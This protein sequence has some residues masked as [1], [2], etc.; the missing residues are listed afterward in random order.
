MTAGPVA[1]VL[2]CE[3]GDASCSNSFR[4]VLPIT[5]AMVNVNEPCPLD[6]GDTTWMLLSTLLVLTMMPALAIFEAGLLRAKNTM[7]II[8]QIV[9]GVV[10]L[11]TLWVAV[12]YSLVFYG[13][14]D[15]KYDDALSIARS[16]MAK[17]T[18]WP[19]TNKYFTIQN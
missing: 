10:L 16:T 12:G 18:P 5:S 4:P 13:N 2:R 8:T 15:D 3:A 6:D 9:V 17:C 1:D 14:L 19:S 11:S 7:S